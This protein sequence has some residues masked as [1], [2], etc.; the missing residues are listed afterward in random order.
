MRFAFERAVEESAFDIAADL[1][2]RNRDVLSR[3]RV[4]ECVG[5]LWADCVIE[6][7]VDQAIR[8]A[9][10]LARVDVDAVAVR[11]D[12][13]VVD[14]QVIH[15]R[16]ENREVAAMENRYVANQHIATKLQRDRFVSP[17]RLDSVALTRETKRTGAR[18]AGK[19]G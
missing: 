19:I 17:T 4:T 14:R 18:L 2:I 10:V 1:T 16:G 11:V 15:T 6:R 7:R 13:H 8:N 9:H 12:L 3:A 5:T